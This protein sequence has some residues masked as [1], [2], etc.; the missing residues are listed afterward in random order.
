MAAYVIFTQKQ[1]HS[2]LSALKTAT[3]LIAE[4][5]GEPV[6]SASVPSR[7]RAPTTRKRRGRPVALPGA[8]K[9]GRG[10]PRVL[11]PVMPQ[12]STELPAD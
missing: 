4:Q 11:A 10:R 3:K 5:M 12:V 7:R 9:R 6:V 1:A 2:I 8:P